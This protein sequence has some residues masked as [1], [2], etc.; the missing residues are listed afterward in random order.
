MS[1]RGFKVVGVD[2]HRLDGDND[3]IACER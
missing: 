3:G 2:V 1:A